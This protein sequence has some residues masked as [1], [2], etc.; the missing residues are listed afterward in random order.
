MVLI[1]YLFIA[2][3]TESNYFWKGRSMTSW[4]IFDVFSLFH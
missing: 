3:E 1:L 2:R 4:V